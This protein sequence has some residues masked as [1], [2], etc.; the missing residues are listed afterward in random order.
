MYHVRLVVPPHLDD[1][2][3]QAID[4]EAVVNVVWRGHSVE[5]PTG[6]LILFDIPPEAANRIIGQLR[7]LELHEHGSIMVNRIG[8]SLSRAA[9]TV[10][11]HVPGDPSEA[12]FWEEVKERVADEAALTTTWTLLVV[13]AV[14][15]AG[16]GL[17]TDS[18]VLVVGAMAVGPEFGPIAAI[19]IGCHV[20]RVGWVTRGL[21]DLAVG[22]GVSVVATALM[23]WLIER[24]G[25][26]PQ[27]FSEGRDV[28]TAFV[29][30]PGVFSALVALFAGVAGMLSLTL[31]KSS[32]LVG[33]LISVTTVPAAAGISVYAAHGRWAD[34]GS[35]ALQLVLNVVV[36]IVA[37]VATLALQRRV[38]R[39][40]STAPGPLVL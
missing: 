36:L 30:E 22:F 25:L 39:R 34:A 18:A 17:L 31:S 3:R 37:G 16:V 12:V 24:A 35:S 33:V 14:L 2:V 7:Q 20:R 26:T 8:T 4:D 19:A 11:A 13:L 6:T 32:T 10:E 5:R 38:D 29:S 40:R 28:Q 15:I 9:E 23:A 21:A 1:A 27:A